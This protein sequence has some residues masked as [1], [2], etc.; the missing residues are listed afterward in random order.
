MLA[1]G[2]VAQ[3]SYAVTGL[4]LPA[5][6]PQI[7][8]HY[9]LTLTQV[10]VVLAASFL[11]S[12]PTLLVWGLV[13]DRIGERFVMAAGLAAA[14]VALVWAAYASSFE[15]LVVALAVAGGVAAGKRKKSDHFPGRCGKIC[16]HHH[17]YP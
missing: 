10:G 1:A 13:A 15:T 14:A 8:S 17:R 11:G 12:V 3:A 2:V 9:G 5:I 6:A 16:R 7:R 4:G